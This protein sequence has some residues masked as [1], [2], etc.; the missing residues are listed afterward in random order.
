[1]IYGLGTAAVQLGGSIFGGALNNHFAELR[2][3]K[4]RQ[5]NYE[6]NEMAANSADERTRLLYNDLYS[7]S[8][9][10]EQ[11]KKLVYLHQCFTA[12]WQA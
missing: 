2:E 1:M 8:A 6:Y 7:P 11:I 4:S 10:I 5:E 3:Q 9:Q 12:I